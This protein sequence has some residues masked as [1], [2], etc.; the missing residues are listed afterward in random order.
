[1]KSLF[2]QAWYDM[3]HQPVIGVVTVIGTALSIFLIM[4]VVMMQA[5]KVEPF[6]PESNRG[7]ILYGKYLHLKWENGADGSSSADYPTQERLYSDLKSA[8]TT[9][10]YTS[11]GR[12]SMGVPGKAPVMRYMKYTDGNFWKV[13]DYRFIAGAPYDEDTRQGRFAVINES[14]AR[15]LFGTTDVVGK[16]I[17][18]ND[19]PMPICGVVADASPLARESFSEVFLPFNDNR[20]QPGNNHFGWDIFSAILA[21]SADDF[22]AIR[23]E[24]QA[25]KQAFNRELQDE[26]I[27]MVDHHSPF[28][29]EEVLTL[30]G[31][32]ND[33]S[34]DSDR[35]DRYIIYAI[36]L[37]VP[38]INLSTMTQSRLRRRRSEIGVRRAF[39]ATRWEIIRNLLAENLIVTLAG[40]LV[41]LLLSALM[42][43]FLSDMLFGM[44]YMSNHI[45]V[46]WGMILNWKVFLTAL[47][48]CFVLNLLSSGIPAWRASRVNPV[49]A[50]NSRNI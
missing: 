10:I 11:S 13:F 29:Q 2:Q 47:L 15:E 17:L 25:R 7:R 40:G 49:D 50:I 14:V 9:S 24:V 38:A 36:L 1:M 42:G 20:K 18:I 46:S 19:W 44:M 41:G 43:Y 4:I 26:G 35:R 12:T 6:A 30:I 37:L 45:D 23:A 31:S 3:R 28:T 8:E 32:N 33:P 21:R 27:E 39:G 48:F 34:A 22:P 5:V 16:E